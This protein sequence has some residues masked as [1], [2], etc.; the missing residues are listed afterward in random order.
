MLQK[1]KGVEGREG[2]GEPGEMV[3]VVVA[4]G[5]PVVEESVGGAGGAGIA[6]VGAPGTG[7][8]EEEADGVTGWTGRSGGH[9]GR[10]TGLAG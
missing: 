4:G 7:G 10:R 8:G 3:P 6:V 1:C 2:A 9:L 5:Q